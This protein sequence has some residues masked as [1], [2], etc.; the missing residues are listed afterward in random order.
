MTRRALVTV[1]CGPTFNVGS[2]S[3]WMR[4]KAGLDG[5]ESGVVRADPKGRPG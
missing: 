5:V 1:I 4:R 2:I 3:G